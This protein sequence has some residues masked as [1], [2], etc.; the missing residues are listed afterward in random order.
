MTNFWHFVKHA[1]IIAGSGVAAFFGTQIPAAFAHA[2]NN[3]VGHIVLTG[4]IGGVV[5]LLDKKFVK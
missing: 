3:P 5:N 4:V 1:A 2:A